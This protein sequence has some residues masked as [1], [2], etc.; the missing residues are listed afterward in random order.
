MSSVSSFVDELSD[1]VVT[2]FTDSNDDVDLC[3]DVNCPGADDSSVDGE[4]ADSLESV[5]LKQLV[6]QP[7]RHVP[8]SA[9]HL[10]RRLSADDR[11]RRHGF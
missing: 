9:A 11:L 7:T 8:G 3:G 2:L 6:T 10:L 5:G 4:L 1:S